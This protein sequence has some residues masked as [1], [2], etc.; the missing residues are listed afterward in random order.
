MIKEKPIGQ[1]NLTKFLMA[2]HLNWA[3]VL[4]THGYHY[5]DKDE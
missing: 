4:L 2:N 3:M 5:L 1:S